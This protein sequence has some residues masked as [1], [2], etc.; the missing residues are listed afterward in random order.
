MDFIRVKAKTVEEALTEASIQ[1]ETSSDNIEYHVI[2]K[3]STGFFGIGSKPAVIE[4]RKKEESS[5]DKEFEELKNDSIRTVEKKEKE[6]KQ[7]ET[8]QREVRQKETKQK[9]TKQKETKQKETKQKETRQK[10]SKPVKQPDAANRAAK[11]EIKSPVKETVEL[12]KPLETVKEK[13]PVKEPVRKPLAD[14]EEV[15]SRTGK[16]LEDMFQAMEIEV[17]VKAV[18]EDDD[19]L[20]IE[21]S[22]S[23]MGILIGKRGQTLD[24]IQYLTSLVA[25][26]GNYAYI[27]VKVD[28]EDYR[29]R[30]KETLE[31]LARN[32][33]SKVRRT[34]KTVFLEPMNP[35]ERRIIHS[36]LQ[37]NPYVSTHSEGE[38]PYR[39]VVV[40][41]KKG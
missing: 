8:R 12:V 15:I 4:A 41:L 11:E 6:T 33:A 29:R 37:N 3:G 30:R 19:N 34:E 24:S 28:T 21:L 22:G 16:F 38:E 40:T 20:N 17:S 14:K 10:Q 25:N 32:V 27:R 23:E 13:E 31:N 39:K 36:A 5:I 26:K 18:F 9:E 2:E 1:L 7:R 35:Y